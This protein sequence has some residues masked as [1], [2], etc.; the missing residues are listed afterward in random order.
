MKLALKPL[1]RLRIGLLALLACAAFTM[2]CAWTGGC[3]TDLHKAAVAT[4]SIANSLKTAA[5]LNHSLYATG[6]IDLAERQQVATLIDQVT[7]ANDAVVAQLIQ[8]EASGGTVNAATVVSAFDKFLDQLN[9]LENNGVL[10]L[11]SAAAQAQFEV[12]LT[13]VKTEVAILKGLMGLP[14]ASNH[15]LPLPGGGG[16]MLA[17]A[18]LALTPEEIETLVALAISALGAGASLVEKLLAMKGET[19]TQLLA[20]AATQDAAARKQ[21]QADEAA[22]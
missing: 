22:E 20:D 7:Q 4:D 19:D 15:R 10:H 18:A 1:R 16:G 14:T 11:K 3:G 2:L 8:A 12:V 5:D 17:F 13:A 6:Q 9:I 21:A